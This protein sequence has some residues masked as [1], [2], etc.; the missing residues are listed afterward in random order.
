M[1]RIQGSFLSFN[2]PGVCWR[3]GKSRGEGGGIERGRWAAPVYLALALTPSFPSFLLS[4]PFHSLSFLLSFTLPPFSRTLFHLPYPF[5]RPSHSSPFFIIPHF[6][7]PIPPP[8]SSCLHV[9]FLSPSSLFI[10]DDNNV[11]GGECK[12]END[13]GSST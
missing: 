2:S 12:Y 1:V 8:S 4:L 5:L 10:P 9:D 6:L 3:G 7:S 11:D 13:G